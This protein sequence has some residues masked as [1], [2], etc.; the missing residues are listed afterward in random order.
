MGRITKGK[1][2]ELFALLLKSRRFEERLIQM[3]TDG[4]IAGWLHPMLGQEATGVGVTAN[5]ERTDYINNTHRGRAINI[6]KGVPLKRF[7]AEVLGKKEGPCGGMAGEMHYNDN[8]YR[9]IGNSGLLGA[10]TATLVGVALSCQYRNTGEVVV[11]FLGEGTVDE[12]NFHE[13]VNMASLWKLPIVFV[14]ENNGW[15]QFV[16]Q[17]ATA[18]PTTLGCEPG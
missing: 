8:E 17:E 2:R 3:S 13:S 1:K 4:E 9:V 11:N 5:L 10:T 7:T 14:V 12:G 15:A 16:P 18:A 6:T